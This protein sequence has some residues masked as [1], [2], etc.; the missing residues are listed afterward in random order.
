MSKSDSLTIG[1]STLPS[2]V[3]NIE[4]LIG[5]TNLVVIQNPTLEKVPDLAGEIRVIQITNTGVA[6]SRNSVIESTETEYLLFG[7]DDVK[8]KYEGIKEVVSFL[9]KNP[10]ISFVL[11]QAVDEG[12]RL[13]KRYPTKLSSLGLTNSA[14]AATYEMV[15]RVA[16]I[17]KSGVRFDENFGAGAVNYL[18]DEFIFIADCLRSGLR[19]RFLPIV[20]AQHPAESSGN[21]RNTSADVSARSKIFSRVFGPWAP[22]MRL[23]FLLK[24][25]AKKFGLRNSI[26]FIFGK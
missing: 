7:D 25:P 26:I 12:G 23:L 19:G 10:K 17:R 18:G 21:V 15:I 4:F 14:K 2:R 24:P 16:D 3:K 5:V 9:D 11:S 20:T 6:K 1:Y 13:R 8:F 22:V